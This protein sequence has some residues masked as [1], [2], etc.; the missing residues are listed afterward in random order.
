MT[1]KTLLDGGCKIARISQ[2]GQRP[3]SQVHNLLQLPILY[4]NFRSMA[5]KSYTAMTQ[6]YRLFLTHCIAFIAL[7]GCSK[8]HADLAPM[9]AVESMAPASGYDSTLVTITG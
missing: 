3:A 1:T 9:L 5:S 6:F 8:H 4:I 7:I 2:D